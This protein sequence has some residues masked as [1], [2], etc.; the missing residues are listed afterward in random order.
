M[1]RQ[2][3]VNVLYIT[4]I[5]HICIH[6]LFNTYFLNVNQFQFVLCIEGVE[7]LVGRSRDTQNSRV[8]QVIENFR[9][10]NTHK[11]WKQ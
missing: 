1:F 4:V 9:N 5:L 2:I 10:F 11:K 8:T 6:I 7:E 3:N